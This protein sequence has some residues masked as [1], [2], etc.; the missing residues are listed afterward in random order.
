MMDGV[1]NLSSDMTD[2]TKSLSTDMTD[3]ED[4]IRRIR[5]CADY[6]K[7]QP[8]FRR[9]FREM[10]KKIRS[11]GRVGGQVGLKECSEEE[12]HALEG[13][14]GEPVGES[15]HFSLKK[16]EETLGTT[17]FRD[18]TLRELMEAYE[19]R[20]LI[21]N[22][23]VREREFLARENER[24]EIR[25]KIDT[26]M[27]ELD[28]LPEDDHIRLAVLAMKCLGDPH[29]LDAGTKLGDKLVERLIEKSGGE[30]CDCE[31][32]E[33][34]GRDGDGSARGRRTMTISASVGQ[35]SAEERL[36]VLMSVGIR[37]DDI[38]NYTTLYGIDLY[39]KD[40]V[41]PGFHA[42]KERKESYIVTLSNLSDVTR[43]IPGNMNKVVYVIE[44]PS[45]F[46][47]LCER[48]PDASFICTA[49]QARVASLFVLDML[50]REDCEIRYSGDTDPEGIQIADRLYRRSSGRI[51][52]WCMDVGSYEAS[53]SS[54]VVTDT[55][56][57]KKMDDL[58]YQPVKEVCERIRETGR[59]GYQEQ[60]IGE[61]A[62]RILSKNTTASLR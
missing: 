27:A 51:I 2:G 36:E 60:L 35:L 38:S 26:V 39:E 32:N 47:D 3:G 21:S 8:G 6:F 5:E 9:V 34:R 19:G 31:R 22:K 33:D 10:D 52:P 42:M 48:C 23:E 43:I 40:L 46:S 28:A 53:L 13:F 49:G 12:R 29:A 57:L 24:E 37:P 14:F 58:E 11:Y 54:V 20:E 17:K 25:K 45:V 15:F 30:Y 4:R 56:R 50:C 16:F 62:E 59:V 44:N 1:E 41:H 7:K 61:M 55:K 18:V